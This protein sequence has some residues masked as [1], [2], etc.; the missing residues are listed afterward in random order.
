VAPAS[1]SR[2]AASR[3]V[4]PPGAQTRQKPPTEETS[5]PA[6]GETGANRPVAA[7][8]QFAIPSVELCRSAPAEPVSCRHRYAFIYP[9]R[10]TC[11]LTSRLGPPG[12]GHTHRLL[13]HGDSASRQQTRTSVRS[14]RGRHQ[15]AVYG[16]WHCR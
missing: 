15:R 1:T 13:I 3:A 8:H 9:P 7:G 16:H 6:S 12:R 11:R 5:K 2:R 10:P 4:G 14:D